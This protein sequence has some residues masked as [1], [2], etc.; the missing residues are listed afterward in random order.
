MWGVCVSATLTYIRPSPNIE[1]ARVGTLKEWLDWEGFFRSKIG[2]LR[3]ASPR[4]GGSRG[5]EFCIL[6]VLPGLF[7]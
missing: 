6:Q 2:N 3:T 5:T 4:L 7:V 1:Y